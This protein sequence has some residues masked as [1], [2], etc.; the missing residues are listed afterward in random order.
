MTILI[1]NKI[2]ELI[3]NRK[4]LKPADV[5]ES[6][7]LSK[8]TTRRYLIK[9]ENEGYIKRNFGEIIYNEIRVH[10]KKI[11]L[12]EININKTLKQSIANTAAI[13]AKD[14]THIYVDGGSSCYYL[15]EKLNRSV[16]LYTNSIYN[17]MYALELGFKNVNVIGGSV[18]SRTLS[19]VNSDLGHLE[20]LTFQI[21]FLGVNGIDNE[22]NLTT[23]D[24]NEGIMKN[25]MASHSDLVVVLAEKR[26][27]GIKSF[28]NFTPK[29]KT[30]L[31]VTNY[32]T[33][34]KYKN[35]FLVKNK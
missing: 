14:Y 35:I 20:N 28:Y 19:T 8:S 10:S 22:G 6:L 25:F 18:K 29:N 27:F 5:E 16:N 31:V 11:A 24:I 1:E 33:N 7:K 23:P 9:L 21:A 34:N 12:E 15:I 13:L 3:K 30:V 17:A 26:K 4:V 2:K 32:E